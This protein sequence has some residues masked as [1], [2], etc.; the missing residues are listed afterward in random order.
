[1]PN[2]M[3]LLCCNDCKLSIRLCHFTVLF[4]LNEQRLNLFAA[5]QYDY[6]SML[7]SSHQFYRSQ[8][9]GTLPADYDIAWRGDAFVDEVGPTTLNW[10]DISGGIMEGREAGAFRCMLQCCMLT[11]NH[12]NV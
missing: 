12:N 6:G 9:I 7:N 11:A 4:L 8:W 2:L 10:G 3:L 1:M 5:V